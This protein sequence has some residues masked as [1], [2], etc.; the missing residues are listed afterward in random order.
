MHGIS[1]EK[2]AST[3][4]HDAGQQSSGGAFKLLLLLLKG[5]K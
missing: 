5:I 3:V 2:L 1:K 4:M